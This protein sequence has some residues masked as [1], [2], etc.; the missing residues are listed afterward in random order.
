MSNSPF[1]T[2]QTDETLELAGIKIDYG[3]YW[4]TIAR[5]GGSN[6]KFTEAI[7]QLF[8]PYQRALEL[9]QMDEKTALELTSEAF[10]QA[11]VLGWGS[12]EHGE[13]KMVGAKGEALDFT[14]D[15]VRDLLRA[16]P[17]Q[18]KDLQV[19]AT[20]IANFRVSAAK[21]RGKN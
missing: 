10:A 19:E 4:F 21:D 18:F 3:D 2:F 9:N 11:V 1:S 15:N 8:T 13:G 5:A 6:K 12:K 7:K 16:L 14:Q 17:E 20:K